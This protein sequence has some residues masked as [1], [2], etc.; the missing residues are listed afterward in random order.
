MKS[1]E[2]TKT[3]TTL[4]AKASAAY[5]APVLSMSMLHAPALALIPALYAKHAAVSVVTIG[6]ILVSTRILDAV[7]DPLIGFWSDRTN[8]TIGRRKPWM[9]VGGLIAAISAYFWLQPSADV[10]VWWFLISSVG[11]YIGWTMVE[12]PHSAWMSEITSSYEERS[13]ISAYR[14][15]AYFVGYLIFVSA[16]L[17]PIFPTTEM[18]PEVTGVMGVILV[19]LIPVTIGVAVIGA[20]EQIGIPSPRREISFLISL[21]EV[22][23]NFAFRML[24][25]SYLLGYLASGMVGSLYF[26]FIDNYL[27]ILDKIAHVGLT[28]AGI[29]L[30][31]TPIWPVILKVFD[32]HQTLALCQIATALTLAGM[33][34]IQP[35]DMAFVALASI[36]GLSAFL[37][38]GSIVC[39]N[40]IL[41][42]VADQDELLTGNNKA[43]SFYAFGALYQKFGLALGGGL[44]LIIAGLFGFDPKIENT[45]NAMSGFFFTFLGLPIV[46]N[47]LAAVAAWRF[48][49]TRAQHHAIAS[50][51]KENRATYRE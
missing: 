7:T 2:N 27:G 3:P 47:A 29:S 28:V 32:K 39:L 33:W 15:V 35:G 23:Q 30:A 16:P 22:G 1:A 34:F 44:G 21:K 13:K 14:T 37:S 48:P 18:T 9:I 25:L 17:W 26:F 42:D 50:E 36:F 20:P 31:T 45:S 24:S 40:A 19:F 46:L 51:L 43:A 41:A 6:I 38:T 4:S 49:I 12:I 10:G 11:V 5:S 8:S